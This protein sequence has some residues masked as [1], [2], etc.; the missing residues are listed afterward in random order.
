MDAKSNQL[1][2]DVEEQ[3]QSE[4][5]LRL[6]V[7]R[8]AD[9]PSSAKLPV[10]VFLH[11]GAYFLGSGDR[12]YYSP[13]TF[14]THA[15]EMQKPVLFISMNY[16][17]GA[18]GFFHSPEA[19][20]LIPANN[21]LHDQLNGFEW[22]HRYIAGFGG[23]KDNITAIGQS[24]GGESLSLHNLSG[25]SDALYKRSIMFSG[26]PLTMPDKTPSEHQTNFLSQAKRL[27]I[28]TQDR[29]S[30]DIAKAMIATPVS[31]IRDLSYVGQPCV[32]TSTIP[33]KTHATMRSISSGDYPSVPWLSSQIISA[34]SYDGSIS[35]IMMRGDASRKEHATSFAAIARAVLQH[36]NDLLR[37]YDLD[38]S[39]PDDAALTRIC[40]FESDIGFLAPALSVVRATAD[41]TETYAQLFSLGNPFDGP[42]PKGQFASHTWD[43][44]ALLGAYEER[45][46]PPYVRAIRAWRERYIRY[47]VDGE[48]PWGSFEVGKDETVLRVPSGGG[49]AREESLGTV[50]EGRL[51]RLLEIA[52]R[53][54]PDGAD[55]L[56]EGVCR[57]WLMKGE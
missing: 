27:G 13:L 7:T 51:E 32:D 6:T 31:A 44:V 57:R 37:L 36:P 43:V 39:T 20:D 12:R 52:K 18:L 5:C 3:E 40:Q 45:L 4:D 29:S 15:L 50:L 34:A 42:L 25:R 21:G 9:A 8:P 46:D 19:S 16:R 38:D 35:N 17:L 11:G 53:E 10:V 33:H 54:G 56:W 30:T 22:L 1:P 49:E 41:K 55:T 47:V 2:Q 28:E 23:D 14:C 24:A 26:T 48:A